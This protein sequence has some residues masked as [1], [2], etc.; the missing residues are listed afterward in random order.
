MVYVVVASLEREAERK[1][2]SVSQVAKEGPGSGGH[3]R[4]PS[5]LSRN[6]MRARAPCSPSRIFVSPP[7]LFPCLSAKYTPLSLHFS[8]PLLNPFRH[9]GGEQVSALGVAGRLHKEQE[10]GK[11]WRA[12]L[13]LGGRGQSM[14]IF[15]RCT[16]PSLPTHPS[17]LR[18]RCFLISLT[19]LP[20]FP[21]A[22]LAIAIA[23]FTVFG[24]DV[25]TATATTGNLW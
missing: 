19:T 16:V 18:S 17:F 2:H 9:G 5:F 23:L 6:I 24:M 7:P 21:L 11:G 15:M 12:E 3:V 13:G 4:F 10:G 20:H 8:F 14:G 1:E 25:D 22:P